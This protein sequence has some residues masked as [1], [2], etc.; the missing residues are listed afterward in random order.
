ME[1]ETLTW[2]PWPSITS[3]QPT[4]WGPVR[5][6]K[7]TDWLTPISSPVESNDDLGSAD[8]DGWRVEHRTASCWFPLSFLLL[9]RVLCHPSTPLSL[10]VS[11]ST[12]PCHDNA[13]VFKPE[14][15]SSPETISAGL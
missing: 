2:R 5:G 11:L 15:D 10:S 1:L 13:A 9:T 4:R 3:P 7:P 14:R 12:Y 6:G 8:L